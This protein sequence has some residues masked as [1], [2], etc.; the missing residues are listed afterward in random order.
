MHMTVQSFYTSE[1]LAYGYQEIE[2][3]EEN[4]GKGKTF[5]PH[6]HD[7]GFASERHQILQLQGELSTQNY[8]IIQE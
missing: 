8:E 1:N 3:F 2:V 7:T 5:R 6:L 4:A